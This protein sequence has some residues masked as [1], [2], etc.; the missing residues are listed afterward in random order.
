MKIVKNIRTMQAVVRNLK[1][2]EKTIGFVPTMGALHEGHLSLIRRCRR[3]NDITVVSIFVNP[4]QFG[5]TEDLNKY[6]RPFKKDTFLCQKEGVDFL[7]HPDFDAMYPTGYRTYVY[8][9]DLS[10]VLCGASRHG[11]F[12]GVT[13]VVAKLFHIIEPDKVYLGQKDAQQAIIIKQ[14]AKDLNLSIKITVMPTLRDGLGLALSSRNAYL[15]ARQKKDALVLCGSLK[16]AK[17]LVKSGIKNS[18]KIIKEI[19]KFILSKTKAKIEYVSIVDMDGLRPIKTIE[20]ACLL[21]LA[22]S[23]GKTRLIDNVIL[24]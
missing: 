21:A 9:E 13:T 23:I 1:K 16:L 7:F 22:V 4:K 14:M 20:S 24:K 6:P 12:K 19:Q 3:E 15:N 2:R 17:S 11:H 8:V 10:E 18:G 5:Q